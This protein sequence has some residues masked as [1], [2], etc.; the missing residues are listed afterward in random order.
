MISVSKHGQLEVLALEN[1]PS[2]GIDSGNIVDF[3]VASTDIRDV[4]K[5][6]EEKTQKRLKNIFVSVKG[7]GISGMQAK[8]MLALGKRPRL[9]SA[10]DIDKCVRIASMIRM[11]EE[12]QII[13]KEI[14]SFYIDEGDKV[15]DPEGLYATKLG[16]ELYVVIADIAKIKNLYK[17]V[18]HSGYIL[19]GTVFAPIAIT[20]ALSSFGKN[21]DMTTA[22]VDIGS[23]LTGIAFFKGKTLF[24]IAS[25]DLGSLDLANDGAIEMFMNSIKQEFEN[26]HTDEVICTGGGALK[27]DLIEKMDTKLGIS[28]KMGHASAEGCSIE[29]ADTICHTG[30]LG[31]ALYQ[32]KKIKENID[33]NWLSKAIKGLVNM[34][35]SYF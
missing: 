31:V 1:I 18:E 23:H 11:P 7:L 13:Q 9:I 2:K 26:I 27:E 21:K 6:V 3:D 15:V 16:M 28:C 24:H 14:Q 34:M 19:S 33:S 22:I 12:K 4:L 29:V 10:S 8:G 20:K 17:C 25:V 30:S 32:A 35:E 5:R